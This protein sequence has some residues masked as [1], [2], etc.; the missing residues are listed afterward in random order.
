[1]PIFGEKYQLKQVF[2]NLIKN[3]MDA[4]NRGP[5]GEISIK[6]KQSGNETIVSVSDNG[7]GIPKHVLDKIGEPFYTTKEKGNGLG[8]LVSYRII[9]NHTGTIECQS[10]EG[11]GTSFIVHFPIS[12]ENI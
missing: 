11:K 7:C 6:C 8:L 10:K 4:L 12:S 9:K 1:V 3:A 5:N 2:I